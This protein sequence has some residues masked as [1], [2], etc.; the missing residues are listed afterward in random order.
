MNTDLKLPPLNIDSKNIFTAGNRNGAYNSLNLLLTM[1][2]RIKGSILF[3][4]YMYSTSWNEILPEGAS[5]RDWNSMVARKQTIYESYIAEKKVDDP[6]NLNS[7]PIFI[8]A[9]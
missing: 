1:S 8:G 3:N 9:N 2:Q 7:N 4:G 5:L 6:S